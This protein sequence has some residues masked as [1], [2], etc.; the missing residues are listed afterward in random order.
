MFDIPCVILAGGKSR[1]MGEDKSLLPFGEDK[2]LTE[3]QYNKL[4]KLFKNVYISSKK[5]KFSI[6]DAKLLLEQSTIYSPMIALKSILE[7]LDEDK[8][9]IVTVDTP[10]IKDETIEK[11]IDSSIDYEIVI[12]KD[13]EKTHNLCG[14]F[15]KSILNNIN[16]CLNEDIH[17]I[18]FLIKNSKT[19]EVLFK[20]SEQFLNLNTPDDYKLSLSLK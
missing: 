16:N 18:G 17:K 9:F 6:V 12:A 19:K 15:S 8:V 14:V 1:R 3:Y 7:S 2:T 11:I 10:F 4:L 13:E 5:D 20:D